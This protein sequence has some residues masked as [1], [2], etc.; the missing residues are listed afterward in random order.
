MY[1]FRRREDDR[2]MFSQINIHTGFNLQFVCK[3]GVQACA[4]ARERLEYLRSFGAAID[5]HPAGSVRSLASGLSALDHQHLR[6]TLAQRNRQREADNA[7]ADNDDVPT[8]HH[9]IVKETRTD[10]AGLALDLKS[11]T[12]ELVSLGKLHTFS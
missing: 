9:C 1:M 11:E 2:A 8:L 7:A 5:E 4:R 12:F 10:R 3:L 6:S